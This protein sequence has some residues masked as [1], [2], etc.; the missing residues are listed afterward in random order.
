MM[1]AW[2]SATKNQVSAENENKEIDLTKIDLAT[3]TEAEEMMN[4]A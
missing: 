1:N 2:A 4:K 3:M